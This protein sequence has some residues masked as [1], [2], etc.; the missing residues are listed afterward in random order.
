[1]LGEGFLS[2]TFHGC[3]P[4]AGIWLWQKTEAGQAR[5]S[6]ASRNWRRSATMQDPQR[7]ITA[8]VQSVAAAVPGA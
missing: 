3:I 2:V 5:A 1:L 6:G 8:V 7:E 4:T